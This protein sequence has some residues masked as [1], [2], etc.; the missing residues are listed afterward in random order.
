MY[1]IVI[2]SETKEPLAFA[3]VQFKDTKIGVTTDYEGKY[4]IESYYASD[5]L[6]VTYL[7]Y[8]RLSKKIKKDVEQAINFELVVEGNIMEEVV[9]KATKT[10]NPAHVIFRNVIKNKPINNMA[11]L[12]GYQYEVY[13][14]VQFDMNNIDEGFRNKKSLKRFDF[15]FDNMDSSETEKPYLPILLFE[16]LSDYYYRTSPTESKEIIKGSRMSGIDNESIAEFAGQMYQQGNLYDNHLNIFGKTFISPFADNGL[17]HYDYYLEDSATINGLWCYQLIFMPKRKQEL[18]F[19]GNVWIHDTTFAIKEIS[20][21]ISED[22]NINYVKR[23]KIKQVFE[24][25]EKEVWM[26]TKSEMIAD[27]NISD[28]NLGFYGRKFTS[29][30]NFVINQP[31]P[32]NF[33]SIE[34]VELLDSARLRDNEF[35]ESVRHDS[36]TKHQKSIYKMIDTLKNVPLVRTYIDVIRTVVTGYKKLGPVQFGPWF[37]VFSFNDVE[38]GRFRFGGR[39]GPEFSKVVE[40]SGYTAYGLTDEKFKFGLGTRINLSKEKQRMLHV[41]Y[42]NDVEQLGASQNAFRNDH[43]LT[44]LFRRNPYNKLSQTE[45]YRVAFENDWFRGLSSTILVRNISFYPLGI[46]P[47]QKTY[48]D[49][50]TKHFNRITASEITLHTRIARGEKF[51]EGVFDRKSLGTK[52]PVVQL[53]F[54]QGFRNVLGSQH[55]YRKIYGSFGHKIHLGIFGKLDYEIEAGKIF[56]TAPYPLLEVHVGNESFIS[57]TSTYNMMNLVEFVSDQ[58]AA[59]KLTHHFEGLILNKIPLLRKLMW[60]EVATFKAVYGSLDSRHLEL[61]DLPSYTT[62]LSKM[63]YMEASIGVD[64]IFK[65]FRT[66]LVWRLNY[67][68]NEFDGIKVSVF[69]IRFGLSLSF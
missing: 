18:T 9:V 47:F 67:L 41:V 7:G 25:V 69:G 28:K 37:T 1:G 48:G 31:K 43:L 17:L 8:K 68:D 30:K 63:P 16:T 32:T 4:V 64:N 13:N 24:Q 62:S 44:S 45:E 11:K 57:K 54:T 58:Y 65:L 21:S 51:I 49:G 23:L 40:L 3:S 53:L 52:N 15:I 42:K 61:M 5:S 10:E 50:E 39:T 55:N 59:I 66:D 38:G 36:L 60:R 46:I 56:G 26:I 35:W 20:S 27:I 19:E 33:F 22:A 14:K 34:K 12:K 29:Y 2:D 6:M